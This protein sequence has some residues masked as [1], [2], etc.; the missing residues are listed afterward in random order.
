MTEIFFLLLQVI[1]I[2]LFFL[3]P[4]NTNLI[5]KYLK[6]KK[7]TIYD[8]YVLNTVLYCL[9]FLILSFF[10]IKIDLIIYSLIFAK[11]I[12]ITYNFRLYSRYFLNFNNKFLFL[13][14]FICFFCLSLQI[15]SNPKLGWDGIGHW[16]YKAL[17]YQ[18][19]GTYE[20]LKNSPVP[21]YPHLGPYIWNIFWS[22]NKLNLEYF[23]RIFYLFIF[24]ITI[25]SSVEKFSNKINFQTKLFV[26]LIL[27]SLT[28]DSFLASGYQEYFLFFLFYS[29]SMIFNFSNETKQKSILIVF[30]LFLSSY[31]MFWVKQEGLFYIMILTTIFSFFYHKGNI[32]K[33]SYIA[34]TAAILFASIQLKSYYHGNYSFNEPLLHM[35]LLKYLDYKIFINTFYLISLE[36]LKAIIKY[37]IWII[38]ILFLMLKLIEKKKLINKE[39]IFFITYFGLIYCIYFQTT[40]EIR[41]LMPLTIDR[42]IFHGSGFFLIFVVK[43]LNDKLS[44]KT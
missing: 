13:F 37:P 14:F 18:Q 15:S 30:F 5:E 20:N 19:G 43:Y 44:T 40:M 26:T 17:N 32:L 24:I 1:L 11:I 4:L 29:F 2:L 34:L 41:W 7:T 28:Y 22:I 36:I 21:Y 38:I 6:F 9:V 27:L 35:G 31:L 16:Y 23:G 12:L 33:L 25:F 39:N 8:V 3:F 42:V 10:K